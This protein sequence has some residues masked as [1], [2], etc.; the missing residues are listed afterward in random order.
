MN[1][2]MVV[3]DDRVMVS[4]LTMLLQM[5][6][7]EVM[8]TDPAKSIAEQV[9]SGRPDLVLIDVIMA[10]ANGIEILDQLRSTPELASMRVIMTSGMDVEEKCR[11]HGADGFLLKPYPPDQ[12]IQTIRAKLESGGGGVA[13][14][15]PLGET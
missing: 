12:L 14:P 1:K 4:L 9:L 6:G 2:I 10:R 15:A 13:A 7:F 3:D 8:G 11:Q 5:D